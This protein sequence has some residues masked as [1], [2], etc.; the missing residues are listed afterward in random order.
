MKKIKCIPKFSIFTLFLKNRNIISKMKR[1]KVT[2][3]ASL[4]NSV[5]HDFHSYLFSKTMTHM[6]TCW[7]AVLSSGNFE[8]L[9]IYYKVVTCKIPAEKVPHSVYTVVHSRLCRTSLFLLLAVSGLNYTDRKK[10][11]QTK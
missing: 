5:H 9:C 6:E 7:V 1:S 4:T 10:H 2:D 11:V 8:T 3:Y